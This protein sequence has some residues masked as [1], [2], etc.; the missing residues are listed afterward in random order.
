MDLGI[1]GL[2]EATQI[3]AGGAAIVYRARQSNL[4]RDVAVKVLSNV[5]EDFVRRFHREAKTLGK[6]S[7]NPGIVT[8][9]D[10]GRTASGQPYLVLELC[11][12]SLLD[13]IKNDGKMHPLEACSLLTDV[14]EA[15]AD[16]HDLGV[17][18][19]DIKPANMLLS[20]GGRYLITDFGI[21]SV[22]GSTAG[23]TSTVGFTAAYAAPETFRQN[24]TG[25]STDVYSIGASLFH[26][27]AGHPPFV[28]PGEERNLLA[29]LHRVATD[30]VPDLRTEGVPSAVCDV[31]E[32]AMAKEAKD[33]P[34]IRELAERLAQAS[35]DQ[36]LA[37]L[38]GGESDQTSEQVDPESTIVQTNPGD[39][40][41]SDIELD[42]TTT[43]SVD[44]ESVDDAGPSIPPPVEGP[45]SN[46]TPANNNLRPAPAPVPSAAGTDAG[47]L[48]YREQ[49]YL[50]TNPDE[51]SERNLWTLA[52]V[53][54]L[55]IVV[56]AGSII[57]FIS[58][59][60]TEL[61]ADSGATVQ[62]DDSAE[63]TVPAAAESEQAGSSTDPGQRANLKGQPQ[64][65]ELVVPSLA[66]KS[67]R[68]AVSQ[69]RDVGASY[70]IT[71]RSSN[72][73]SRGRVI[74]TTP[75]PNQSASTDTRIIVYIS[76]GKETIP[77]INVVGKTESTATAELTEAG[78]DLVVVRRPSSFT[79]E[80]SVISTDPEAGEQVGIG[81]TV[82]MTISTGPPCS[83]LVLPEF[84]GTTVAAATATL[85]EAGLTAV[86][87]EQLSNAEAAGNVISSNPVAG[88]CVEEAGSVAL[89]VS[90]L[91]KPIPD[92]D[93]MTS[94]N[95]SVI[96]SAGFTTT[97]EEVE[98]AGLPAGSV[99]NTAPT[100]G[101]PTCVGTDVVVVVTKVPCVAAV[102]PHANR[103]FTRF[104]LL[105]EN[106]ELV[107]VVTETAS[108]QIAEGRVITSTPGAG[109]VLCP[110]DN[111]A[112]T[113]STGPVCEV[114]PVL[115][116]KSELAATASLSSLGFQVT[117][118]RA[119]SNLVA[120]NT[121]VSST[122]AR[123]VEHCQPAAVALVISR[124][125]PVVVPSVIG[126]TEAAAVANLTALGLVPTVTYAEVPAGTPGDGLV[127]AQS[128]AP[129]TRQEVQTA[130]VL[131]VAKEAE[132]LP[133]PPPPAP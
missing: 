5:D 54:A 75:G 114:L 124:G 72:T 58:R 34:S 98:N 76:T 20:P 110:G 121:V 99:V 94:A 117:T 3:G 35:S 44:P 82:T 105:L 41:S 93:G 90:C 81:S 17:I 48:S 78:F 130:I 51:R 79:D 104:E 38:L 13:K 96:T 97:I 66:G 31:I 84:A 24:E 23:E 37:G 61:A 67:E 30:P 55:L 119:F 112:V 7:Q 57:Y 11:K 126:A 33:R 15:V 85:T 14:T 1:G 32:S 116:G 129:A 89:A 28:T 133:P 25:P 127:A 73:V 29:V 26:L 65:T 53:A 22:S 39:L 80:G 74:R 92:T 43:L 4:G 63:T 18:H 19:R 118:T 77:I 122:P 95:L 45:Q 108:A 47:L 109:I 12:S 106:L 59:D 123:G 60:T 21:A 113:V 125:A 40:K 132:V 10:T 131:T 83:G 91:A 2:G 16:A 103:L 46:T 62:T 111:V 27:V 49:P 88:E 56:A 71:Y 120:R 101:T 102:P 87:T 70:V 68:D 69:L 64:P 107:P 115:A 36:I 50:I 128:L 9:Y 100:A 42:A 86:P 52:A 6:L 8:V